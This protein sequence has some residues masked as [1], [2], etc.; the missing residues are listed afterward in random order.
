MFIPTYRKALYTKGFVK[1]KKV[2]PLKTE[3]KE[4]INKTTT[5][6]GTSTKL[7]ALSQS[8]PLKTTK[9][10]TARLKSET[11]TLIEVEIAAVSAETEIIIMKIIKKLNTLPSLDL[12]KTEN[13]ALSLQFKNI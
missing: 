8:I 2:S 11:K 13:S 4:T 6:T 3:E 10:Q 1:L 12:K 9:R 5:I 7:T